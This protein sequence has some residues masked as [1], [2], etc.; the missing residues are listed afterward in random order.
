MTGSV[1]EPASW[2]ETAAER[3][4]L[5]HWRAAGLLGKGGPDESV[6]GGRLPADASADPP[7]VQ[8]RDFLDRFALWLGVALCAAG[9][10]CLVAANWEHLGKFA[11]LAGAQALVAI[12]G[13]AAIRLGPQRVAGQAALWLATIAL[14]ALLALIGQTYQTGADT[15]ELFALWAALAL[16][17]TLAARNAAQW[18]TWGMLL[19][20]AVGLWLG[21]RSQDWG[22]LAFE[23]MLWLGLLDLLLLALWELAGARW[24]E[25]SGRI[26]R[27]LLAAATI[28]LLS[29]AAMDDI[30]DGDHAGR[31]MRLFDL[32]GAASVLWCA[33]TLA[34]GAFHGRVRR[35]LPVLAMLALGIIAVVT[36]IL[37]EILFDRRNP[38]AGH[39]LLIA[40]TVIVQAAIAALVLRRMAR[41]EA[42]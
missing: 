4:L 6:P 7:P 2:R 3:A 25:F 24:P 32:F 8:W 22:M 5:R 27:R 15:W 12:A 19:N 17:W 36:S 35:D 34:I 20:I 37:V 9:V 11:R 40:A 42:A 14:G 31:S 41:G 23:P 1:R 28:M 10:I 38:L 39:Y 21:L 18:L 26:G 33:A 30:L 13:L 29:F 16:P